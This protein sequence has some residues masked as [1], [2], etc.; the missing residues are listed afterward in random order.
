M[1][2]SLFIG[3]VAQRDFLSPT[4]PNKGVHER[5][6]LKTLANTEGGFNSANISTDSMF[7]KSVAVNNLIYQYCNH[8]MQNKRSAEQEEVMVLFLKMVYS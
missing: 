8:L 5:L 7:R 1:I 3:W 4:P 6:L 2:G